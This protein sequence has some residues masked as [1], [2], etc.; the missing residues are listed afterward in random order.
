IDLLVNRARS[1][2]FSTAPVPAAAAAAT[3]AIRFVQ[4]DE[5]EVRRVRLWQRGD[6][7]KD[8]VI[9]AGWGLPPART[10]LLPPPLGEGA[11][12][13]RV[14]APLRPRGFSTRAILYHPVARGEAPLPFPSPAA[15]TPEDVA[16]L[17]APLSR[18]KSKI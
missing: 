9:S 4:S 13:R 6:Q 12:A 18:L 14:A 8:A 2:I 7:V 10:A 3:A 15:H 17:G 11:R 1:F 5:G 16:K